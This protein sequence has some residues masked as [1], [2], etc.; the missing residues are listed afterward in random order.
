VPEIKYRKISFG[1][2]G[3]QPEK[4]PELFSAL[5][6]ELGQTRFSA[7]KNGKILLY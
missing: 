1:A 6:Q 5:Y 7:A 4:T 3:S 2:F